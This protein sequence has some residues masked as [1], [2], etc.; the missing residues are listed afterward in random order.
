MSRKLSETEHTDRPW[1]IHEFTPD[2]RVE[3]V[4]AFRTPGAGPGD[5]RVMRDALLANC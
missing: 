5:F 2:F 3:D 4:W 1:R